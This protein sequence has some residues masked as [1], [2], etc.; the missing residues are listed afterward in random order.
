MSKLFKSLITSGVL[1]FVIMACGKPMIQT[2]SLGQSIA[3]PRLEPG[4]TIGSMIVTTGVDEAVPLWP[5]C[6]PTAVNG[7]LITVECREMSFPKLAIGHTFGVVELVPKSLDWSELK[8]ELYLD[9]HPI[10]L[11][12]FG[13]YDFVHPETVF[14]PSPV[15]EAFRK[16]TVWD[17]VLVDPGLGAHT[18][19]GLARTEVETYTWIVNFIIEAPDTR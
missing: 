16:L 1:A 4:D 5:F 12:A 15:R 11:S 18:L 13:T 14:S 10:N 19:R 6:M 9:E 3:Y 7:R 8:W 2:Q 17:I